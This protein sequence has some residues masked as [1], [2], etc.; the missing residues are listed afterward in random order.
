[1]EGLLK[2]VEDVRSFFLELVDKYSL[3]FHPDTP[4]EE[5]DVLTKAQVNAL[6]GNMD[7]AFKICARAKLVFMESALKFTGLHWQR[8]VVR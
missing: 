2:T 5:F 4:F 8:F 3:N 7:K 1:L 6:N